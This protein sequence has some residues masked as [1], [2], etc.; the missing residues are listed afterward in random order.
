[1]E[2]L[3][4]NGTEEWRSNHEVLF[5]DTPEGKQAKW[6]YIRSLPEMEKVVLDVVKHFGKLGGIKV[7][8]G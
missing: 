6:E 8:R 3:E 2:K 4:R 1:M 7:Y 5:N